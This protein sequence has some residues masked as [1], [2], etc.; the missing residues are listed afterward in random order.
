MDQTVRPSLPLPKVLRFAIA[1]SLLLLGSTCTS[2]RTERQRPTEDRILSA[3]TGAS[4]IAK[5]EDGQRIMPAKNYAI[6]KTKV[7]EINMGESMTMA[8]LVVKRSAGRKQRWW[9]ADWR[10]ARR[11]RLLV[12]RETIQF[13]LYPAKPKLCYKRA[14]TPSLDSQIP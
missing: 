4:V 12:T 2:N 14:A 7:G 10:A 5:T 6:W 13:R 11:E 8:P 3:P 1:A 9:E